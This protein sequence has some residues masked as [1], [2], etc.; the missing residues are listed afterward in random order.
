MWSRLWESRKFRILFVDA[1]LAIVTIV[2]TLILSPENARI[3]LGLVAV[4]QVPI[5]AVIKG[6]A[7]EDSAEKANWSP[8][9]EP[10][11]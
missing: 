2:V 9:N 10:E 1:I 7:E 8:P 5:Y 11:G 4:W 3:V 6:I